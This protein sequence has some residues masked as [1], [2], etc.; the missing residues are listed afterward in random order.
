MVFEKLQQLLAEEFS[1]EP[2]E[3]TMETSFMDDL[4]ADSLDLVEMMMALEDEFGIDPITEEEAATL[5]TVGD[6]VALIN[7]KS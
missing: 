6:V 4:E 5:K 1:I 2:E 3:I 7:S